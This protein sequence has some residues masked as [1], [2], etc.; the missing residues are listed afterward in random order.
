VPG[1]P[2]TLAYRRGCELLDAQQSARLVAS[3]EK[4]YCVMYYGGS[5]TWNLRDHHMFETLERLLE[6]G[7]PNS[8]AVVWAHNSHIG[9]ARHSDMG[10]VRDELNIGQLCQEKFGDQAAL[11]GFSTHSGEV[12][13]ASDWGGEM[14]IKEIR[15]SLPDSV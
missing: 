12:A 7:G 8:K 10:I 11:I 6:P 15:P 3:A 14:E 2:G 5:E 13:C 4:Y 1:A 9:D